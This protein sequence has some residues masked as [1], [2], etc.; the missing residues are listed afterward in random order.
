MLVNGQL[1]ATII[2]L[3]IIQSAQHVLGD[4]FAH[5]QE[6]QTVFAAYGIK[7]RRCCLLVTSGKSSA[8]QDGRNYS[9]KHVELLEIIN[10]IITV[11]S[12]WLF[13]LVI[14]SSLMCTYFH[15]KFS[16]GFYFLIQ[17]SF[18]EFHMPRS[19]QIFK[20]KYV[21]NSVIL[22]LFLYSS[23]RL[24]TFWRHLT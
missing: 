12:S 5:L 22:N 23:R 2:I 16:S 1:N 20:T 17:T 4:N 8:P 19:T 21:L 3:L 10:K 13:I 9:P 7:H 15:F 14:L 24:R 6:H 18:P 11:A